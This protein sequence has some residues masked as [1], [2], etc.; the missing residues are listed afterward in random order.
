MKVVSRETSVKVNGQWYWANQPFD[1]DSDII[2]DE[3]QG[4]L[5]EY[6][7][8]LKDEDKKNDGLLIK[9]PKKA[10]KT[11]PLKVKQTKKQTPKQPKETQQKDESVASLL[12]DDDFGSLV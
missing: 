3:F 7:E 12:L 2:P 4:L 1:L 9:E 11:K 6:K 5:E 8:E 10:T